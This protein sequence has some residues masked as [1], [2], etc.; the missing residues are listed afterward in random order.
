MSITPEQVVNEIKRRGGFSHHASRNVLTLYIE[1][2]GRQIREASKRHSRIDSG[3]KPP[4]N[5]QYISS[6]APALRRAEQVGKHDY[7][8]IYTV[9]S[10]ICTTHLCL[11]ISIIEKIDLIKCPKKLVYTGWLT[12]TIDCG[13]VSP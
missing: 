9:F 7:T 4:T 2:Q 1:R 8:H 6:R 13:S 10:S 12:K 3:Q 11:L 5:Q